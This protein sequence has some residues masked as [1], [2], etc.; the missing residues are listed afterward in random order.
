MHIKWNNDICLLFNLIFCCE[1]KI[2]CF[3]LIFL[4]F[5]T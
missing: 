1:L 2:F 4:K 5:D 3:C